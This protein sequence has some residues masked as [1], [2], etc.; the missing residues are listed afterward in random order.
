M[1]K[2]FLKFL[3]LLLIIVIGFLLYKA[4]GVSYCYIKTPETKEEA[5]KVIS[6]CS[7]RDLFFYDMYSEALAN[8]YVKYPDKLQNENSASMLISHYIKHNPQQHLDKIEKL[9]NIITDDT[10]NQEKR[11][12]LC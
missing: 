5:N 6:F 7:D 8:I 2:F 3:A 4:I 10:W 11:F 9:T 12:Y 1:K